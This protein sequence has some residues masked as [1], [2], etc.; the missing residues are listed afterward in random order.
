MEGYNK[1]VLP[2]PFRIHSFVTEFGK[3]YEE[4]SKHSFGGGFGFSVST[5]NYLIVQRSEKS[6]KGRTKFL[7]R[8][9]IWQDCTPCHE[10]QPKVL[11]AA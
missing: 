3:M 8:C 11:D 1:V 2:V 4:K 6:A 9:E 7:I 5:G 10:R